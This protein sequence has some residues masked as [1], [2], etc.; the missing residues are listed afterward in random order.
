MPDSPYSVIT[1]RGADAHDFLQGQLSNDLE[2]LS[3]EEALLSA[4]CNP[5]GRVICLMRVTRIDGGYAL[6]VPSDLADELV[7]RLLTFRFRAKVEFE[8]QAANGMQPGLNDSAENQLLANLRAGIPEIRQAQSEKFT[9]HMLNLDLLGAISFDKGC[10]TGQ[11]VVARTHYRGATKRRTLHFQSAEPVAA[12]DKVTDGDRD[13][14]EVLNAIGT[15]LLAVI[16]T[17]KADEA[18]TVNGVPL[19]HIALPY[20]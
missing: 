6:L 19:S 15:D 9:P 2:L 13:I 18:L 1:A 11:E 12:G 7:R 4:W 20:I 5:K 10:Y 17:D 3:K 16:P 14:G 8:T